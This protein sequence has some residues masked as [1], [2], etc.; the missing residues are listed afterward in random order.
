MSICPAMT[1]GP[2]SPGV[3]PPVYQ[4]AGKP[5]GGTCIEP[6]ARRPSA[7]KVVSTPIAGIC[8]RVGVDLLRWGALSTAAAVELDPAGVAGC[9]RVVAETAETAGATG[10][11]C[12][13]EDRKS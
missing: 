8:R 10:V 9:L 3:G 5:P 11:P 6:S 2:S 7:I 4:P 13:A 1:A 12:P